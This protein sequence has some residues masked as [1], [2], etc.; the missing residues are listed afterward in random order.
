MK[1]AIL[2]YGKEMVDTAQV[3][4]NQLQSEGAHMIIYL[5]D[6]D[7]LLCL[8]YITEDEFLDHYKKTNNG[9]K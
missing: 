6:A 9:K 4:L 1:Y 7:G 8:E 2:D 5:T 3:I